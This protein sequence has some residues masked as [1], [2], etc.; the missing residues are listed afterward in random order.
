MPSN[1]AALDPD[2]SAASPPRRVWRGRLGALLMG[3]G[4]GGFLLCGLIYYT[5]ALQPEGR[6]EAYELFVAETYSETGY[7]GE[8]SRRP[9]VA[10]SDYALALAGFMAL[11]LGGL[12]LWRGRFSLRGLLLC[13]ALVGAAGAV[14]IALHGGSNARQALFRLGF[15]KPLTPAQLDRLRQRLE[16]EHALATWPAEMRREYELQPD[17]ALLVNL[18]GEGSA[19]AC[20]LTFPDGLNAA[21]RKILSEFYLF[22]TVQSPMKAHFLRHAIRYCMCARA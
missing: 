17:G 5:F 19:T 16:P 20:E 7:S 11:A 21:Q 4:L 1:A 18:S 12:L 15:V 14:P 22:V 8:T 13:V 6:K 2:A 10:G 9:F 3:L